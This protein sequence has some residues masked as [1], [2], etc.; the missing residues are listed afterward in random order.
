MAMAPGFRQVASQCGLG[1]C[2]TTDAEARNQFGA[3]LLHARRVRL[4]TGTK[5]SPEGLAVEHR[6]LVV[7]DRSACER[8]GT[9]LQGTDRARVAWVLSG[10]D[11]IQPAP[12]TVFN[13]LDGTRSFRPTAAVIATDVPNRIETA[14]EAVLNRLHVLMVPPIGVTL[15]GLEELRFQ[16]QQNKVVA[17]VAYPDRQYSAFQVLREALLEQRFGRPLQMIAVRG[18]NLPTDCPNYAATDYADHLKGGGAV[19]AALS[20]L[21]NLG[22]WLLGPIERLVADADRLAL[23]NVVVEDTVHVL[24]RHGRMLAAYAINQHQL[25][26]ETSITIHCAGGTVR[27]ELPQNRLLWMT[28]PDR[29]WSEQ[30]FDPLD[31]DAVE[32]EQMHQ[33][34]NVMEG[35]PA[36]LCTFD[37]AVQS[38]R[39][40]RAVLSSVQHRA[41]VGSEAPS[42][43]AQ[44]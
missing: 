24:A 23:G 39:V 37:Q 9:I 4:L 27:A 41:W 44:G 34:L 35:K 17:A 40:S 26:R 1:L 20:Y 7:G 8:Y 16:A 32:L 33:F 36:R 42:N 21:V 19:H 25:P 10:E 14:G 29:N 6:V 18:S 30:L 11:S 22:E 43:E 38:L 5:L 31:A 2:Y 15:D 3:V 12:V 28:D 13:R